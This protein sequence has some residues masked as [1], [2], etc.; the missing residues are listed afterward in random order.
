MREKYM[1]GISSTRHSRVSTKGVRTM[2]G[3]YTDII[4]QLLEDG[5]FRSSVFY[6]VLGEDF[7]P[8]AFN[9][10]RAADA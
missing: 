1:L 5:S 4:P 9:T 8:L 7:I 2:R 3:T 10:A 6:N